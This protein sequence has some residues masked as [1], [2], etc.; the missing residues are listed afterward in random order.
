MVYTIQNWVT[1]YLYFNIN[2]FN[3][4]I[5]LSRSEWNNFSFNQSVWINV[6]NNLWLLW[7]AL[8]I[9]LNLFY[10]CLFL[11][12]ISNTS[13][14]RTEYDDHLFEFHDILNADVELDDRDTNEIAFSF[15]IN[16]IWL[17]KIESN[18]R[19]NN[20]ACNARSS[21]AYW[22]YNVPATYSAGLIKAENSDGK[23]SRLVFHIATWTN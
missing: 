13:S 10:F 8:Y 14:M 3:L 12:Y 21:G 4:F 15:C 11:R 20:N 16:F 5:L 17:N 1:T 18:S 9:G 6:K 22:K 2:F 7:K 23:M 19:R